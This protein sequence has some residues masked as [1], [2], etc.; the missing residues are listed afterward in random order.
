MSV[1]LRDAKRSEEDQLWIKNVYP[2]Y[3]D[4]LAEVSRAGTGVFPVYGEHGARHDEL[5]ARWFRDDRSHPLT[6]LE[7]GRAVGFALVTRTL[8]GPAL[9]EAAD[10]R[11]AEFFIRRP[12]RRRGV[13]RAAAA[14]IFSRFAGRWEI[15]E[16]TANDNAVRFWRRT[17]MG[18]TRGR[19]DERVRD[20][21]VRQRFT[22]SNSPGLGRA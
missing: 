8:G 3:L 22:S 18:Y 13:G 19:Y 16:A 20:G 1:T 5:L 11:M 12:C 17:V 2:E 4:E 9:A 14:I 7:G 10:F 6:I 21:E 15:V